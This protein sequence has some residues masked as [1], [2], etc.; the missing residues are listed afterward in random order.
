M[1]IARKK[2]IIIGAGLTGLAVAYKLKQ[3]PR[4]EVTLL[5]KG[6]KAGGWVQTR[7]SDC[8]LFETGPRGIRVRG[9]AGECFLN[10]AKELGLEKELI[11][12][13]AAA[14]KRYIWLGHKLE[15]VSN[16]P[17]Q[18]PKSA[19]TSGLVK[20]MLLEFWKR[21]DL[22]SDMSMKQ[23]FCQRLGEQVYKDLIDPAILGVFGTPGQYLSA[24]ACLPALWQNVASEGSFTKWGL[25]AAFKSMRR[26]LLNRSRTEQPWEAL[27]KSAC[28]CSFKMGMG[29]LIERLQARLDEN[30]LLE[31]AV[32]DIRYDESIGR[33]TVSVGHAQLKADRV[34]I[35]CA[36]WSIGDSIKNLLSSWRDFENSL[37]ATSL[38]L[39]QLAYEKPFKPQMGFGYLVPSW[40]Q[41]PILGAVF[42]SNIFQ[43]HNRG[44]AGRAT[45]M[46]PWNGSQVTPENAR[47]FIS[48]A[49]LSLEKHIGWHEI[50]QWQGLSLAPRCLPAYGVGHMS[51]IQSVE[52]EIS[53]KNLKLHL[54]GLGY[55]TV[56]LSQCLLEATELAQTIIDSE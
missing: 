17:W 31:Q 53:S 22:S 15:L 5:E 55:R 51:R 48:Q 56:A 39:V 4:Y 20:A 21:T 37:P 1:K 16:S 54:C 10:W 28:V 36:P 24:Q 26:S 25:K 34:I 35:A 47:N 42:D 11:Y 12:S 14:S 46:L 32:Q 23:F 6:F 3:H 13:R 30:L 45:V 44:L 49:Q 9:L 43:E 27:A 41:E 33:F 18:W 8:G 38:A 52:E 2:V 7:F 29:Q 50:A 40:Q 19:A